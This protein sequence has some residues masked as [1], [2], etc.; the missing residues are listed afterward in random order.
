MAIGINKYED[1]DALLQKQHDEDI[2]KII[3]NTADTSK[4]VEVVE[5]GEK[6]SPGSNPAGEADGEAEGAEGKGVNEEYIPPFEDDAVFPVFPDNEGTECNDE[7][8]AI[9]KV[10][11]KKRAMSGSLGGGEADSGT[12][13]A[14]LV[15][16]QNTNAIINDL[17][18]KRAGAKSPRGNRERV[19]DHAHE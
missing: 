11:G 16:V 12:E 4:A 14:K 1:A 9:M 19:D 13:T 17:M 3:V 7:E 5:V 6:S 10:Q 2:A 15:D 18:R 8:D